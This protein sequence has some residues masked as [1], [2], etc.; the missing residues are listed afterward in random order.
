ML[1]YMDLVPIWMFEVM[2]IS[3]SAIAWEVPLTGQINGTFHLGSMLLLLG[4][5]GLYVW[6]WL[7]L[8][9]TRGALATV[10]R[11]FSFA[12]GLLALVLAFLSPVVALQ[13]EYLMGRAAQQLL[14]GLLAPPLL[15]LACPFH[16][17]L[18]GL[19]ASFRRRTVS[20]LKGSTWTGRFIRRATYPFVVWLLT[21][22]FFLFWHDPEIANWLLARPLF[23]YVGLWGLWGTSM[24]FWWHPLGTGPRLHPVMP[25]GLGFV[26]IIVGGEVP[27]MVTGMTL[28]FRNTPAYDF[29]GS[30]PPT[31]GLTVLQ[32]QMIS[33]GMIWFLGSIV[34]VSVAIAL[35]SRIFRNFE[36]SKPPPISWHATERTIAPGLEHRVVEPKP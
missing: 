29:Y 28:A 30:Q 7:R 19:P 27:N 36:A 26:Y 8:R 1:V 6:G 9:R 17:I 24:L 21:F 35:L 4:M 13:Q 22:V 31:P 12:A 2:H 5:S 18:R 20:I 14:V 23:Y 16:I 11:L 15:W 34:Y 3:R 32:D 33:G 10:G 25:A